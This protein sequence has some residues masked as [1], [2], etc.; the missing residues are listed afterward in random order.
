MT[1]EPHDP[2][3]IE[4]LRRQIAELQAKLA[5]AEATN[6]QAA[7]LSQHG[8]DDAP[9]DSPAPGIATQGG[10]AIE[11]SVQVPNGHFI[12]RDFIQIITQ[13]VQG[14]EDPA[15]A[16]SVIALYLH[17][18]A[19][20]L[21]G[22]KLGEIDA[23]AQDP[24][25]EPLQLADVYVPLDTGLSIPEDATLPQWLARERDGTRD[26]PREP[27]GQRR[28]SALEALAMHRELKLLGKPGSGKSTFGAHV[29]LAL[30][31]AWQGH[32]DQLDALGETWSHG[33][34]L[35]IRVVLRRFADRLPEGD[36]PVRAG[37]LWA[38]I[39]EELQSSGYGLSSKTL[40]YVQRIAR[41]SG[42]LILLDGLDECGAGNAR[43]RVIGAVQELMRTAG[44]KCR[45]LLTARPY[46]WPG[47]ADPRRGVYALADL[48]DPQIEQ[49]IEAWYQ[50]LV[51]RGWRSPGE[52]DR[53]R[54]DLL[55]ARNRT[56]LDPLTRNPL[57]LTLMATLHTNRGRL[58]DDRA[59]LYDESVQLLMLRWNRQIGADK[60][61]LEELA[62]PTLKL[63]DLRG[64]LE[65]LAF[66][67]HEEST[68]PA[69]L[70]GLESDRTADVG[71]DRLIRSLRPLLQNSRDK[72]AVV[73]DYIE[74]RAGLLVGQGE[75]DD[76]RQFSFPHRTIQEFLAA[77]HL[78]AQDDFPAECVR[79]ARFAPGHW[80]VALPLAA[81]LAKVER[82]SSAADELVGG[83]S[84]A[85][86]GAQR[87][88][89]AADWRC[90]LMAGL[91]LREIGLGA[92]DTRDRT[93]AIKT[94]VA[95]WLAASLP[96]HPD[97]G[98]MPAPVRALAGDVLAALGDP[99]FDPDR[100][101]LP[102]DD[103]LGFVHVPADPAFRIGTRY[104]DAQRIAEVV[105]HEIPEYEL[106]D[107]LTP[108][109]DFFI[110]RYP[111]TVAQFRAFLEAT[112]C[113]P[114]DVDALRDTESR[115]VR[116]I[117]WQEVLAYCRWLHQQLACAPELEGCAAANLVR[118]KAWQVA[119]PSELEWEKAAR[120][121]QLDTIFS[122]G[123]DPNPERANYTNS[124]I[125]DTSVV[126]CF[127]PNGFGL[128]DL[129]GNTWEWT[130][131][132]WGKDFRPPD[133]GYP[134]DPADSTREVLE[135]RDD[136]FRVVRGGAWGSRQD[137]ARCA[138]RLA[139]RPDNRYYSLG[140]RVVL[141]ASPVS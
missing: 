63:A 108:T 93:R 67:L 105:G 11:G 18:L 89:G 43:E 76:E 118:G 88:P 122:W 72:A 39:G 129:L 140:F 55:A 127:P 125:G 112:G 48:S 6:P 38:H 97:D 85:E 102:A 17:V 120:G 1:S 94:R 65:E 99:R 115:P 103:W 66:K 60:A 138:Y 95:G 100:F 128:H 124:A 86:L 117:D 54:I 126:G 22:L 116:W 77:C 37:D 59:D 26:E 71:E 109:S 3:G 84:I 25:R 13:A 141:R 41:C 91:Q 28:V 58:P 135:A 113:R 7:Q 36:R 45:F 32:H 35:P 87:Q 81:R 56:D 33:P 42:A 30:A 68:I 101:H 14:G 9:A 96:V 20:D 73:V 92:V 46:A 50:A 69:N 24:S 137:L 40:D 123:D 134:Y 57:L 19:A 2:G 5:S 121:G 47:G 16:Q 15:E 104:S 12:G 136:V 132:L 80:Q 4:A 90:A 21:A 61:L 31:Q 114:R 130:R 119:L 34:L 110:A 139:N 70:A 78:Q 107:A 44:P 53:K 27:G 8:G 10:A 62:I 64:A 52:A 83:T 75:M 79:L 29:L 51:R 131:S 98:G 106:N 49:F 111:V 82:G 23:A 133:F 74:K